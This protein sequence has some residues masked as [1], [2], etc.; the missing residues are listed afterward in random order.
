MSAEEQQAV[1]AKLDAAQQ[2]YMAL[3][4]EQ[5]ALVTGTDI[6]NSLY[7]FFNKIS[8]EA[9]ADDDTLT[10]ETLATEEETE[11]VNCTCETACTADSVN[12]DCPVCN[13][14]S[15]RCIGK[16]PE[17]NTVLLGNEPDTAV[18]DVQAL[19][20]ALPTAEELKAMPLEEQQTV[21]AQL[22]EAYDAYEALADEQKATITGAEIFEELFTFF[23][24]QVN[25]LTTIENVDYLDE[26]GEQQICV[27]AT[28]V[29]EDNI[30]W[31]NGWYVVNSDVTIDS[32][33]VVCGTA[34][35]ILADDSTLTAKRG[36]LVQNSDTL[37]IYAQS[38]TETMGK[39]VA[40]SG[41]GAAIGSA[42][43]LSSHPSCGTIVINGGDITANGTFQGAGI[44]GGDGG[45]GG[46]ITINGGHITAKGYD[47]GNGGAAGI[48]GGNDASAGTITINGGVVTA[49]G[50]NGI[51]NLWPGGSGIG[52]G[53][54]YASEGTFS[55]SSDGHAI[56]FATGG[57]GSGGQTSGIGNNNNSD[58]WRGVIFQGTSGKVYGTNITISDSFEIPAGYTLEI[59]Q[60]TTLT[61]SAG[62]TITNNGEITGAGNLTINGEAGGSGNLTVTGTVTKKVPTA[63]I[64]IWDQ[65][66][67]TVSQIVLSGTVTGQKYLITDTSSTPAIESYTWT[68]GTGGSLTFDKLPD[69]SGLSA[70]TKYYIWTYLPSPN[71]YYYLDSAVSASLEADTAPEAPDAS[72]VTINYEAET[73][74][75]ADTLEVN[76]SEQFDG[77]YINSDNNYSITDYIS[78][79]ATTTIYVRVKATD[80]TAASSATAVTIPARPA[81]P[82]DKE[83]T[84]NSSMPDNIQVLMYGTTLESRIKTGT[85][86]YGSWKKSGNGIIIILY[87]LRT[88][89][90]YTVQVR[91]AATDSSFASV[92][93]TQENCRTSPARYEI[94]IPK[95]VDVG[96]EAVSMI[97]NREGLFCLGTGGQV[98]V[99]VKSGLNSDGTLTLARENDASGTTITSQM[100]VGKDE[101]T[102]LTKSVAVFKTPIAPAVAIS[103]STPSL[104]TG[105]TTIPAGTYTGTVTFEISYSEP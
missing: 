98:D 21:Y 20:N 54:E 31:N 91:K 86:D 5:K 83:F 4:D 97:I 19:I 105:G 70:G 33:I 95:T 78:D 28:V 69:G 7:E 72:T 56:I 30:T 51:N 43:D 58:S 24:G 75:F 93:V 94:T 82:A 52:G 9:P 77:N 26:D 29:T 81:A 102:D 10:Q 37:Y 46:N 15:S 49:V 25:A 73:I 66:N 62:Y 96:G 6:F 14:D 61:V 71:S 41:N 34:H 104:P 76:T 48:G 67:T 22:C 84:I 80:S 79:T 40:T 92:P 23:N 68:D 85:G 63:V 12:A 90:T 50:G 44:G 38:K 59:P 18:T 35:L 53:G 2:A 99:K 42:Y 17:A 101:F 32:E 64:P 36:I 39:I 74:S 100:K 87:N 3:S 55:T 1:R 57:T 47:N 8:N 11:K 88:S 89:D 27:S 103:F 16:K 45:S 60:G 13:T 65:A